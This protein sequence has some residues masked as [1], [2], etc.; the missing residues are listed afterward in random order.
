MTESKCL[1]LYDEDGDLRA[2]LVVHGTNLCITIYDKLGA[3]IDRL[4]SEIA[5]IKEGR[6]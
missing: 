5:R 1:A 4:I 3:V 6:I 2:K